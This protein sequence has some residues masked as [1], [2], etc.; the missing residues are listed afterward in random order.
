MS[1]LYK[2]FCPGI[3]PYKRWGF[4]GKSL[5]WVVIS[6][7]MSQDYSGWECC[8]YYSKLTVTAVPPSFLLLNKEAE[9][10]AST[11]YFK[12]D[13]NFVPSYVE[14]KVTNVGKANSCIPNTPA[15]PIRL[16]DT[17]LDHCPWYNSLR[18]PHTPS[19]LGMIIQRLL[20]F[21]YIHNYF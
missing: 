5:F 12:D 21:Y 3:A 19:M 9:T 15:S 2:L 4:F 13:W 18:Y 16:R 8:G 7:V 6:L 20:L 14:L 11:S 10:R 17:F 1:W